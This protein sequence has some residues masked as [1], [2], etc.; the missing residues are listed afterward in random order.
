MADRYVRRSRCMMPLLAAVW[1]VATLAAVPVRA[2]M[3]EGVGDLYKATVIVTG[4]DTRSRPK[5]FAQALLKGRRSV[6]PQDQRSRRAV[7]TRGDAHHAAHHVTK[8][9]VEIH[10]ADAPG[11]LGVAPTHAP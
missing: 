8:R 7:V 1:I 11:M 9:L 2:G 4:Y 3:A 6:M 5:G 10:A